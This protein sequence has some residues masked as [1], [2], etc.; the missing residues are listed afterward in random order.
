MW[1]DLGLPAVTPHMR[2]E[3]LVQSRQ[4]AGVPS[5]LLAWIGR[6][7]AWPQQLQPFWQPLQA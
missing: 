5:M 2:E 1:H 3:Q 4:F 6:K 7:L